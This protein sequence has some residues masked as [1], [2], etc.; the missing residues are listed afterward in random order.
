LP[1]N[2]SYLVIHAHRVLQSLEMWRLIV[3][4]TTFDVQTM[5]VCL[6]HIGLGRL[7]S[8]L[9]H[10]PICVRWV[11]MPL[12]SLYSRLLELRPVAR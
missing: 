7:Y 12:P 2:S 4:A 5:E 11:V 10:L 3:D 1:T 6:H 9:L 8:I